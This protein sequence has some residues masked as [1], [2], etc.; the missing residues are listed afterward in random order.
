MN[1]PLSPA[2]LSNIHGYWRA[3]NYLSVGQ[4]YL[5]NNPLLKEPLRKEHIKLRLLGHWG[6]SPGLNLIYV[7]LNRIIAAHDLNVLFISGPGH[8]GPS[9]VAQ[10][11]LEGTYSEVYPN[12]TEDEAGMKTLFTQFSFPGL[13]VAAVPE[14]L[15]AVV[16]AVLALVVQRM[17]KRKAI[18]RH[19]AAVETL[20][21]A[22]VIA[23]DKTGTLTKNEMTQYRRGV[24]MQTGPT[25]RAERS[26]P[27]T[28]ALAIAA[29][30][31][32]EDWLSDSAEEV[33]A[34][35]SSSATG[36]G[37]SVKRTMAIPWCWRYGR[38][39]VRDDF[40][41]PCLFCAV[42]EWK[43]KRAQKGEN[44]AVALAATP[45]PL[46]KRRDHEHCPQTRRSQMTKRPD[47]R[48]RKQQHATRPTARTSFLSG[49][50]GHRVTTRRA[51]RRMTSK[52]LS[53]MRLLL[54]Q[55][56]FEYAE[57]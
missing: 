7:H 28:T 51:S 50:G 17:A 45:D 16:T 18:V 23:S 5:L 29:Q 54:P 35:L 48:R 15:P 26:H 2:E 4:I 8:G 13:A 36:R 3:S 47:F 14:G 30:L 53:R 37:S 21:S 52:H 1:K 31:K 24:E 10:A 9:L 56:G 6:T 22:T 33:L 19:L 43:W 44:G 20:G 32:V 46:R 34:H 55:R 11:Y 38:E 39:C 25:R 27:M 41:A 57:L 49:D 12:V 40:I 42:E